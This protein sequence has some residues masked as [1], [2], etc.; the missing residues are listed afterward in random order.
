MGQAEN[1]PTGARWLDEGRPE[2]DDLI[3]PSAEAPIPLSFRRVR[4]RLENVVYLAGPRYDRS[5]AE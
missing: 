3:H 1:G 5:S 2:A 4:G